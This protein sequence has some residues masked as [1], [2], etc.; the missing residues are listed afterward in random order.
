MSLLDSVLSAE[1]SR[2]DVGVSV[3]KMA[4]DAGVQQGEAIVQLLE[5]SGNPAAA[6]GL[7]AYA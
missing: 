3:L 4:Q 6:S 7:D 5:A 2:V 1:N